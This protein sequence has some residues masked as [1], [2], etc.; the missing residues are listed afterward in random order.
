M[1]GRRVRGMAERL[2]R[3]DLIVVVGEN[4]RRLA[5]NIGGPN[6]HTEHGPEPDTSHGTFEINVKGGV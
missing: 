5:V 3:G 2:E 1:R 6:P 4:M